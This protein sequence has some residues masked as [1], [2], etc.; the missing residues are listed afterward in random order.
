MTDRD[1]DPSSISR[2]VAGDADELE[3]LLRAVEPELRSSIFV[4][5][6]WRRSLEPDDVLQVSFL[7]AFLRVST[8][9]DNSPGAFRAW[10]RRLVRN[11]LTDAIRALESEKRPAAS[12]RVT[13][14]GAGESARTLLA[15]VAG[16][17]A[18]PSRVLS[19]EEQVARLHRAISDLPPNYQRVVREVDL[20][21]R[22]VAE[23]A[24][25]MGLSVGHTHMIRSRA[26]Q[27]LGELLSE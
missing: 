13:Q 23:L 21:E 9:K 18:T 24:R 22:T 16:E 6:P 5:P 2:A 4:P 7:E 3:R 19:A 15:S 27:R 25:D 8:L 26:H 20:G 10:I 12:H 14:G 17:T 11:N 1:L